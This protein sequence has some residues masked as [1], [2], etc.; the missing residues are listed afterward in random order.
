MK[1][2]KALL[3]AKEPLRG[4]GAAGDDCELRHEINAVL[5]RC[6]QAHTIEV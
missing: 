4:I 3:R 2:A 5:Q 1:V 6:D